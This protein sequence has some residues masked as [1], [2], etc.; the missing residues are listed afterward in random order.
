[1]VNARNKLTVIDQ[2]LSLGST[3]S[4]ILPRNSIHDAYML[5]F[6]ITVKNGTASSITAT[7]ADV[8]KA[9]TEIKVVTDAVREHYVLNGLDSAWLTTL[10]HKSHENSVLN[11]A[12]EAIAANGTKTYNFTLVLDEGDIVAVAHTSVALSVNW[13][14]TTA[15][16]LTVQSAECQVT[17]KET[18][19]STADLAE[20]FNAPAE[21]GFSDLIKVIE[22]KVCAYTINANTCTEFTGVFDIPTNTLI[23]GAVIH[24]TGTGGTMPDQVGLL[25]NTPDR[26]ELGKEDFNVRRD[27]DEMILQTKLPAG[28]MVYD[29]GTQWQTNGFGKDGWSFAKHDIEF[30][31]KSTVSQ[32]IRYIS[33]ESLVSAAYW[34]KHMNFTQY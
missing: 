19:V 25:R 11:I 23:R 3:T 29:F 16:G 5:R 20:M 32:I 22:P 13:A 30:A 10:K 33:L 27:L 18:I 1:M 26:V 6:S 4:I 17:I 9:I 7:V 2:K 21:E 15:L 28:L 8:L 24:F 12:D 31:I 14:T 34:K